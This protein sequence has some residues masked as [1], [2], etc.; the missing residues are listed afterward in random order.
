LDL[1]LIKISNHY[2]LLFSVEMLTAFIFI[3]VALLGINFLLF[4]KKHIK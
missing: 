3:F 2:S 1:L 4:K